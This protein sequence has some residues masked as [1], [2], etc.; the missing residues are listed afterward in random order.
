MFKYNDYRMLEFLK[1]E[2]LFDEFGELEDKLVKT[3]NEL[4]G[5]WILHK[6]LIILIDKLEKQ[7]ERNITRLE[8]TPQIEVEERVDKQ[9][10]KTIRQVEIHLFHI[11][12]I[13]KQIEK[14][15]H[16]QELSQTVKNSMKNLMD[17]LHV[18][19]AH[20]NLYPVNKIRRKKVWHELLLGL[21]KGHYLPTS[22]DQQKANEMIKKFT[23]SELI[24]AVEFNTTEKP[25]LLITLNRFNET[26]LHIIKKGNLRDAIII[27]EMMSLLRIKH[28]IINNHY[29]LK[30]DNPENINHIEFMDG[31][32][33]IELGR[34]RDK[35]TILAFAFLLGAA[36]ADG[37]VMNLSDR[38]MNIHIDLKKF[39]RVRKHYEQIRGDDNPIFHVDYEFLSTN[40]HKDYLS[41]QIFGTNGVFIL[42]IIDLF[43]IHKS[44]LSLK[45]ITREFN[46]GYSK[47]MIYIRINYFNKKGLIDRIIEKNNLGTLS[48]RCTSDIIPL[49]QTIEDEFLEIIATRILKEAA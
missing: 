9:F 31:K 2:N 46:K 12:K 6:D 40:S 49:F 43:D 47:E 42:M 27:S 1:H 19:H 24:F 23:D 4:P 20:I 3:Y 33:I 15:N 8:K 26:K 14:G 32:R 17:S 45:E 34:L 38:P 5:E 13:L 41:S 22:I 16:S 35:D 39:N 25:F 11:K 10:K 28:M 29:K 7:F 36:C 21:R 18:L 30:D 48:I 44:Q 37:F